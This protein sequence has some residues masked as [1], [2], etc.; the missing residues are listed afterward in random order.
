MTFSSE[1]REHCLLAL[2]VGEAAAPSAP[3]VP[4][5]MDLVT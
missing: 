5:P 2:K 4:T 3:P 1:L